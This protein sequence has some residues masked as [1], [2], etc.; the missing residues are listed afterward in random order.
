MSTKWK[1]IPNYSMYRIYNDGTVV[2]TFNNKN[3]TR[4]PV[5]VHGYY[6]V[7]LNKNGEE[8]RFAIHRLVAEAF[9]PNPENKPMVDHIDGDKS[10][11]IASNLRWVTA[12]E[13]SRNPITL[14][15]MKIGLA[16][17]HPCK[18]RFGSK[19][20]MSKPIE[21]IDVHG[22]IVSYECIEEAVR[23]GFTKGEI[24]QCCRGIKTIYK[25]YIW[26]FKGD[27][28]KDNI[29]LEKEITKTDWPVWMKDLNGNITYYKNVSLAVK[30]GYSKKYIYQC[31][32]NA[33]KKHKQKFIHWSWTPFI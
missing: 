12:S 27:T 30:E 28:S 32:K 19:H 24:S 5:C 18:G 26:R 4:K 17:N 21:R 15:R 25:G 6:Y 23:D 20:P 13:N 1:L 14:K 22:N 2:S 3:K 7:T 33:H 11:N 9:I 10:N 16:K 31:C 8:R 29:D